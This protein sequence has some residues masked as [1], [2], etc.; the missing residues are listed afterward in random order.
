MV[1]EALPMRVP[2]ARP[3]TGT[4]ELD[5]VGRALRSGTLSMGPYTLAFEEAFA[6]LTGRAFAIA[7]SSG[8]AALHLSVRALGLKEGQEVI[9]TPFSFVASANCVLY[10]RAIPKFADIEERTLGLDA[11]QVQGAMSGRVA[12]ILA[13]DVF[14]H[15]ADHAA[16][17]DVAARHDVWLLED[18][19]EGLGSSLLGQ[20]LGS[21][22]DAATFAFYANKQITTG[23]GGMVVT[24]NP[25]LAAT[26]I[27]QRNQG[28]DADGTWL[29]HT[30]LG[31]NYRLDELS[32]AL[33][34]AQLQRFQ[35]L[36][37]GRSKVAE[38]YR[39]RL[40][41]VP[42]L[43]VPSAQ[44]GT[45]VDWFVYVVRLAPSINRD[46][47]IADMARVGIPARPY[48][49]PIHLQPFY[50]ERFGYRAGDF[51]VTERIAGQSL[52]LPFS[53]LHT[54]SEI[55]MVVEALFDAVATQL[56]Q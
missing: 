52:A 7:C 10:E 54:E 34:V 20:P 12:G 47:V 29:R 28:R 23:E 17:A 53:S 4:L 18:S 45:E 41:G 44:P 13:V 31:Y 36:Q 30:Q 50:A 21:F 56:G 19:C 24:D 16:L 33:G 35:E 40:A 42:W 8:T 25:D 39:R 1:T 49:S 55:E 14:G 3:N 46:K 6:E 43:T 32:A 11:D 37:T 38:G 15:P 48:F 2:M 22:G 9:T 26:M 51:P 27:S 5:L